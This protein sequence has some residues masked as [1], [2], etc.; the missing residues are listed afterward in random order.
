M[1][2][3]IN[4]F[5]EIKSEAEKVYQ[6]SVEPKLA[7]LKMGIENFLCSRKIRGNVI[8][9]EMI[10]QPSS[11]VDKKISNHAMDIVVRSIVTAVVSSLLLIVLICGCGL[12]SIGS[13]FLFLPLFAA[14]IG[15]VLWLTRCYEEGNHFFDPKVIGKA[16]KLSGEIDNLINSPESTD[17]DQ[18]QNV[19]T[20]AFNF[21]QKLGLIDSAKAKSLSEGEKRIG[22][23]SLLQIKNLLTEIANM[24]FVREDGNRIIF[25]S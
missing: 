16:A 6:S 15:T 20:K 14:V 3:I 19:L 1:D 12:L 23:E 13:A 21:L 17:E 11:D 18:E 24:E 2:K 8:Y 9:N 5:D 10:E 25:L 4:K 7:R 22:K